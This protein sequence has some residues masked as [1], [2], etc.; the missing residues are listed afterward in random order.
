L[1]RAGELTCPYRAIRHPASAVALVWLGSPILWKIAQ[2]TAFSILL[3]TETSMPSGFFLKK[4][5][6]CTI[7]KRQDVNRKRS[8]MCDIKFA[9]FSIST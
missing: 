8:K 3:F 4:K 7:S 5:P 2:V 1:E 9:D 6:P